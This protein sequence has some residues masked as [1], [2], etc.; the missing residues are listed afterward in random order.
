MSFGIKLVVAAILMI[1]AGTSASA[2][3]IAVSTNL[4]EDAILTPNI[5]VEVMMADRQSVTFDTSIAPFKATE[6]LHNKC[7]TLR[8]G[9]KYWFEQ[10]LYGH[11]IGVDAVATSSDL[12]IGRYSSRDQYIG[13][14]IGYGYSFIIGKRFNIIPSMGVGVAYGKNYEGY[15]MMDE[16]GVGVEAVAVPAIKPILTRFAVTFQYVLR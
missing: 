9:Y 11:Y 2:Q 16:S 6:S 8:A 14:G 3:R 7:M 15:D 12:R 13:L 5:G 1:A 4:L 10:A